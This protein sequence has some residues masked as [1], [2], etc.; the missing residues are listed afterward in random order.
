M[1]NLCSLREDLARGVY[2][3]ID[4]R[5]SDLAR[6][7]CETDPTLLATVRVEQLGVD[8]RGDE[9]TNEGRVRRKSFCKFRGGHRL[10]AF[11]GSQGEAEHELKCC[12]KSHVDH[13]TERSTRRSVLDRLTVSVT[14]AF[15]LFN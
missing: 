5:K 10:D 6:G 2:G 12:R 1:R 14:V 4:V 13:A 15:S 3:P 9:P 11:S 8:E 7:S